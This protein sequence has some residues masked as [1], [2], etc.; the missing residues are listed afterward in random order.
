[1]HQAHRR[2]P[3][4]WNK[5]WGGVCRPN[6]NRRRRAV[7]AAS[8]QR[9][10]SAQATRISSLLEILNSKQRKSLELASGMREHDEGGCNESGR[11]HYF[12]FFGFRTNRKSRDMWSGLWT[13]ARLWPFLFVAHAM[14]SSRCDHILGSF[15][16]R[17]TVQYKAWVEESSDPG[18]AGAGAAKS[19]GN[20][21]WCR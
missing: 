5:V 3:L 15:L 7:A 17:E 21:P 11:R 14:N 8:W 19:S 18:A 4:R 2:Q 13:P 6:T 20:C 9:A 1:V 12:K 10:R 16:R